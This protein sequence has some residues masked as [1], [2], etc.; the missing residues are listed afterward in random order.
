M[1]LLQLTTLYTIRIEDLGVIQ[2]LEMF[3]KMDNV[4]NN[5]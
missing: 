3:L 5:I 4:D 1:S 2:A